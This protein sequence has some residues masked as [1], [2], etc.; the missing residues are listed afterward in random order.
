M[1]RKLVTVLFADVVGS[2]SLADGLDPE[3]LRS[4]LDS[5]FNAMAA[6]VNSWGGTVEKFI[7]DAVMAV[8]GVPAVRED[9]AQ[10]ALSAALEMMERLRTLNVELESRHGLSLHM[11][12]GVNTGDVVTGATG[13]GS[14]RLVSGEPVNIAARLQ[15]EAEPDSVLVGERTYLASRHA[16]LFSDPIE[17]TLKGKR[18]RVMAR[19]ILSPTFAPSRGVRGLTT[20]L[21]GRSAELQA[22]WSQLDD[23][24]E[25]RRPRLVTV[26]GPAGVGK[27]RLVQEFVAGVSA[28]QPTARILLGRCLAAGH[29]ITYWALGEILRAASDMRLDDSSSVAVTKLRAAIADE[30]TVEALAASAGIAIPESRIAAMAPQD[31][32]DELA[33]A[34]P[35][36]ASVLAAT[37]PCI[38]IVEDLHWAGRP[39]LDMLERVIG[40]STGPLLVIGTARPDLT[41]LHAGFGGGS[42]DFSTLSLRPLSPTYSQVLLGALLSEADLPAAMAAVVLAKAEGNPFFLE[43]IIRRLMEEGALVRDGDRWRITTGITTWPLPDSLVALLSA[44]IDAIPDAEKQVLQEAAV[45]GKVFWAEPL[46]RSLGDTVPAALLAL[47]RRGFVSARAA[48]SLA[49]Q[50]E[51]SFKHTLVRDVAYASLPK[52]RRAKAHAEVGAWIEELAGDRAD[53]F[54]ELIADH[55]RLAVAG[56]DVDLAWNA[57]EREPIRVKAFNQLIRAGA[58]ARRRFAVDKAIELHRQAVDIASGTEERSRSLEELGDDHESAYQG[59]AALQAYAEAHEIARRMGRDGDRARLCAKVAEMMAGSP[60]GFKRSPDPA[61]AQVFVDEGLACVTDRAVKVRLMTAFGRVSR[62]YRGSEPFGQG[63]KPDPIPLQERI[64]EVEQARAV[65]ESLGQ[66][67][68]VWNADNALSLL[69]GMAG[70][71][72]K[73]LELAKREL[74]V[75][76]QLPSRAQQGDAVRR[77]AVATMHISGDYEEGLKLARR[78]LELSRETSPHQ[79]MHGT[80]PVMEALYELG[81]WDEIPPVLEEHLNAFR[82]DPAVECEFVRDGP[83]LGAVLAARTGDVER[84][85]ELARLVGDP[86]NDI[87]GATS[88]QARL[89]VALGDPEKGRQMSRGKALENRTY[90]PDHA[91]SMLEALCALEDWD[92]LEEFVP[93]ARSQVAG[94]ALLGPCCDRAE[95][96]LASAHRD[97]PGAVAALERALAG[98]VAHQARAE[99]DVTRKLLD[100]ESVRPAG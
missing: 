86:M 31:V 15:A 63:S 40:R 38:W 76:E 30:R 17:L 37:E 91:R 66:P 84:A 27:S 87:E 96:L 77:A 99:A 56:D 97:S 22:L 10:R 4:V 92:A 81:R 54:G 88:W 69:Y 26:L 8:F 35:R 20:P 74:E 2:T 24:L 89:E 21:V 7:G 98:F 85:R 61:Q 9:D 43:E 50:P 49:S 25:T 60:G 44:R 80:F 57:S 46:N 11:R 82:Q 5:Y 18:E 52:S 42:E 16:F 29:G 14:Q 93:L 58:N 33:W 65:A 48:S 1:E 78:S 62:L 70:R 36:F 72:A 79:M 47:E 32:A 19:R 90:G 41:E 71:Y 28:R 100:G 39:L 53:E 64:A 83:V 75:V 13:D 6:A 51:Y 67:A 59:D 73:M 68:L 95:G 94:L 12:V 23:V 3:R 45:I 55:Y 34:W